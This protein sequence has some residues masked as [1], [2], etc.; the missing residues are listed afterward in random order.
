[1]KRFIPIFGVLMLAFFAFQFTSCDPPEDNQEVQEE[2]PRASN[3]AYELSTPEEFIID[4]Y[5]QAS[6]DEQEMFKAYALEN[7]NVKPRHQE[8]CL[9]TNRPREGIRRISFVEQEGT[10]EPPRVDKEKKV[11]WFEW[12]KINWGRIV[13]ILI[14]LLGVVEIIVQLTPTEKDNAWFRWLKNI[15]SMIVPNYKSGGGIHP[16]TEKT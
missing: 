4:D 15:V 1:M 5:Y 3:D 12:I 13:A 9:K 6:D 10:K 8:G 14:S 16:T 2:R 7:I 11:G